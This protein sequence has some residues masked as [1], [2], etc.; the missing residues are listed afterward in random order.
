MGIGTGRPYRIIG[1]LFQKETFPFEM[2][3]FTNGQRDLESIFIDSIHGDIEPVSSQAWFIAIG[4]PNDFIP[5]ASGMAEVGSKIGIAFLKRRQGES[6]CLI[7]YHSTEFQ[8][9]NCTSCTDLYCYHG[10]LNGQNAS[11]AQMKET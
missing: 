8:R 2:T 7:G 11:S 10:S 9:K 3:D 4:F 5:G 1:S 6:K